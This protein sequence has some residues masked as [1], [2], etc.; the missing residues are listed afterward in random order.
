VV[1]AH[2]GSRKEEVC[3]CGTLEGLMHTDKRKSGGVHTSGK[4]KLGW[5]MGALRDARA[6][7]VFNFFRET[8]TIFRTQQKN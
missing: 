7:Y 5:L 1:W 3:V 8:A 6:D 4:R 2:E